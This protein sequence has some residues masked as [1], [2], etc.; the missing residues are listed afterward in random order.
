MSQENNVHNR[1]HFHSENFEILMRDSNV[2]AFMA[3]CNFA[4]FFSNLHH[5][6]PLYK[7]VFEETVEISLL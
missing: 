4:L 2:S 7:N 6:L 1:N 5:P 3:L